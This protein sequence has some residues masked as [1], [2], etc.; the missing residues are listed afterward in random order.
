MMRMMYRSRSLADEEMRPASPPGKP[1]AN[2]MLLVP[3]LQPLRMWP[4]HYAKAADALGYLKAID[5]VE[6][7]ATVKRQCKLLYVVQFFLKNPEIRIPTSRN[8]TIAVT[9]LPSTSQDAGYQV[10]REFSEFAKLRYNV[11]VHAQQPRPA[12]GC[13]YCDDITAFVGD[14]SR[15]PAGFV[16]K[17]WATKT[18]RRDMMEE[19]LNRMV[20]LA[21]GRGGDGQRSPHCHGFDLIPY[22]LVR[23]LK[24]TGE[25]NHLQ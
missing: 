9:E 12:R 25:V 17:I 10:E 24:K 19:Y 15:R 18:H 13:I 21:I 7:N 23:F 20:A 5:H 4:C 8:S 22:R 11:W 6:V 16:E 3:D 2:S 1:G 14:S